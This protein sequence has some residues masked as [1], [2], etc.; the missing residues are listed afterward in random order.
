MMTD[1]VS[2]DTIISELGKQL[3]E[4]EWICQR[5]SKEYEGP[6]ESY[7]QLSFLRQLP[8]HGNFSNTQKIFEDNLWSDRISEFKFGIF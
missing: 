8:L 6:I 1:M 2:P 3:E 7:D 5:C 4:A